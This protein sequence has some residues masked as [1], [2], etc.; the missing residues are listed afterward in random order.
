MLGW[1][2]MNF[3]AF[4]LAG[5][6]C[7]FVDSCLGM[8][9]GVTS[10]SVLITFGIV[11]AIASA[12]VHTS[13]A[14]VDIVSAI[15]HYR[16]KNIDFKISLH[17]VV[18]GIVAAVLGALFLSGLSLKMAKPFV[19]V[20]LIAMGFYILYKHVRTF[21]PPARARGMGRFKAIALGFIAAFIDVAVGGGWGPL[22]TPALILNGEEPRKAV[23]TIEFTEPIISLVAVLTFGVTLGFEKFLWNFTLPMILGGIILTPIAG[24][25]TSKMPRRLLGVLIGVWLVALNLWGLL[26]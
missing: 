6:F 23:G 3:F 4:L 20:V 26:A 11:P 7:G 16:L 13:E 12:S 14:V 17:M 18:P 24:F 5:L 10:A 22:G 9:Y 19:R 2:E 8:G 21:Q 1:N 25:L 15:T